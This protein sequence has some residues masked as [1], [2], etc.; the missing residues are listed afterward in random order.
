MLKTIPRNVIITIRFLILIPLVPIKFFKS[1]KTKLVFLFVALALI[2]ILLMRIV[3][4]PI[5]QNALQNALIQNLEGVGHKQAEFVKGWINERI[6][7]AEVITN[8]PFALLSTRINETDEPFPELLKYLKFINDAYG[9]KEIFITDITG[10]IRIATEDWKVGTYVAGFEY[11]HEALNGKTFISDVKPSIVLIENEHGDLE[12]GVPT[13]FVSSPIRAKNIIMGVVCMRIDFMQISNLMRSIKLGESGETYLINRNGVMLTESRFVS[14]LKLSGLVKNRAALELKVINP[15]TGGLTKSVKDCLKG[16]EGFDGAGYPDYRG[17][18]VIGF[19]QWIPELQWGL[20]SEI[21]FDEGYSA[22][23]RLKRNIFIIFI[24]AMAAVIVVSITLA[25]TVSE[26]ILHLTDA[27]KKMAAGDLSQRVQNEAD[28]E[29]GALADSFNIMASTIKKRNEELQAAKLHLE[30]M[31]DAI[32][33]A[34]TV[35]DRNGNILKVNQAAI[36]QY[37]P[38]LIGMKCYQ[39][40]KNRDSI[41]ENCPTVRAIETHKPSSAEHFISSNDKTVLI[42]SYP[43]LD[44]SGNLESVIKIVRDITEQKKLEKELQNYTVKL[45]KTVEE[46]TKDLK[47]VNEELEKRFIQL[48]R[49][50]KELRSLDKMKDS[51]M[52]DV[53]HELKSPVAQVKMAIDLWAEEIKKEKIDRKKQEMF[54]GIV[55]TNVERLQKTIKRILDLSSLE[56]GRV[57]FKKEPLMVEEL[58]NQVVTGQVLVAR[59]KGLALRADVSESLPVVFGD[60]EEIIRVIS[61]L[62]DNAIKYTEKGHIVISAYKN[63]TTVEV[64]VKDTGVGIGLPKDQFARLFESFFQERARVDGAGVGLAICRTVIEAH[65]GKIWVESEGVGKGTTFKFTMPVAEE[66]PVQAS[67]TTC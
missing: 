19:W 25:K 36:D 65:G 1:I 30:S 5:M 28:D 6:D 14:Q 3:A 40:Y 35:L 20:I 33:D 11:F 37:G 10:L 24:G 64:A 34:I 54:S 53:S 48:E 26:P 23:F 15:Q 43:L 51:I 62:I 66:A 38:D 52:R 60:R 29:I 12:L 49:A 2:P 45:E 63:D 17:V 31:F 56:S 57:K 42:S 67:A 58:I 21:D 7:D 39:A 18:K 32:K 8:N 9:Y 41:C 22:V 61:N 55:N 59:K 27:T 16:K 50:N 13:M 47:V 44:S 4:Y 46:R